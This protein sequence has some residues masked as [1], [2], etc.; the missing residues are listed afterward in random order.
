LQQIIGIRKFSSTFAG[1]LKHEETKAM[2]LE[3]SLAS[4]EK[5]KLYSSG[6]GFFGELER[7]IDKSAEEIHLQVYI[8]ENDETGLRIANCLLKAAIRGVKIYLL[9]DAFGSSN[10]PAEI[11]GQLK[12]AGVEVKRYGPFYKGG[13]FHFGR[14]LH[15]KVMVFDRKLAIV[16]GLNI[17]NNYNDLGGKKAWLDFAVVLEGNVVSKLYAI[18]LQRWVKKPLRTLPMKKILQEKKSLSSAIQVRQND[19]IR[20]LNEAN[21]TYRREIKNAA[22][23]LFIVGGYFLPGGRVRRMIRNAVQRGVKIQII[24]AAESDVWLQRNAVQYLYHW[25]LRNRIKIFEYLP[26]NVHGKVLIADK[27][28]ISVGSYDLNNLSTLSNI[29]L[30][31]D[32]PN[33]LLAETL[34]SELEKIVAADCRLVTIEELYRRTNLWKRF[35]HFLCYEVVKSFFA[36]ALWTARKDEDEYQ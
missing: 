14:R 20:G 9:I 18:C 32:I 11:T 6:N 34:Q 13:S 1:R 15:R 30:N 4:G 17:S 24:I 16:A 23:S 26:S 29:E 33:E 5:I 10:L 12:N 21:A 28:M 8:F 31:I 25:M 27:K 3:Q 35:W 19:R 7:M 2:L 36:L 22:H